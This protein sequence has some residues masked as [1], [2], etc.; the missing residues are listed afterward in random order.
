MIRIKNKP[1]YDYTGRTYSNY[2]LFCVTNDIGLHKCIKTY[3]STRVKE[4]FAK[5]K[6][7]CDIY[8]EVAD[9]YGLELPKNWF[10]LR[11]INKPSRK[12]LKNTFPIKPIGPTIFVN[13][14]FMVPWHITDLISDYC[15]EKNLYKNAENFFMLTNP[16]SEKI[17][18]RYYID[19]VTN[20]F[21]PNNIGIL[22]EKWQYES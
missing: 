11:M 12:L 2:D 19:I 15:F 9:D 22:A 17:K 5:F 21:S 7:C 14:R 16:Y 10:A 13:C 1:Y 20:K 6:K 18:H 4:A 3:N 8:N